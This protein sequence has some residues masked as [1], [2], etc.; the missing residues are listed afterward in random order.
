MKE[1]RLDHCGGRPGRTSDADSADPPLPEIAFDEAK[2]T[3]AVEADVKVRVLLRRR[4]G[5]TEER[6]WQTDGRGRHGADAFGRAQR[7]ASGRSSPASSGSAKYKFHWA[8]ADYLQR[9]GLLRRPTSNRAMRS[10]RRVQL[11]IMAA[12]RDAGDHSQVR[13]ALPLEDRGRTAR[14]G[15]QRR[16]EAA[17]RLHHDGRFWH[18]R[19]SAHHLPLI[20]GNL[21]AVQDGVPRY[22]RLKNVAVPKKLATDWSLRTS[23][24]STGPV[25]AAQ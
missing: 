7:A 1:C 5:R 16:E 15:R 19:E 25:E 17:S 18:H 21:S 20:R 9:A 23:G 12:T 2:F 11:A 14:P 24:G 22:V 10:A 3:A 8:V 6:R 13:L 4:V